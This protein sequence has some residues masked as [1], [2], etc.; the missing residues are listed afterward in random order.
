[1][2]QA[3]AHGTHAHGSPYAA[4]GHLAGPAFAGLIDALIVQSPVEFHFPGA[5]TSDEAEK[6]W[7]WMARDLGAGL[8]DLRRLDGSETA[9]MSVELVLPELMNRARQAIAEAGNDHDR[10]RR[11]RTAVGGEEILERVPKIFSALKTRGLIEKA[12]GFGRAANGLTE[13]QAL[14]LA[15]QSMPLKDPD[16]AAILFQAAV[17]QVA[18]P[19]RLVTA[20]IKVAGGASE[21]AMLRA[22]FGPLIDAILCHAQDQIHPLLQAGTF[23]DMDLICRAVDRFHRLMRAVTAYIELPRSSNWSRIAG[24]LTGRISERLDPRLRNVPSDVN[25]S[26]RA[27]AGTDRLDADQVFVALSGMYLL[28]AVRDSRDSLALNAVFDDVWTQIGQALEIHVDRLLGQVKAN[29]MDRVVAERFEAAMKMAELR[30]GSQFADNIR[31]A[32][33]LAEKRV[34]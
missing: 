32:K 22:G 29:P 33:D 10:L 31:H 14:A 9:H 3:T 12:Q 21:A 20:A 30:F 13:E 28:A 17:G 1:M 23:T 25:L 18:E 19:R 16:L 34:G 8:I 6:V 5:I 27:R 2:V 7:V 26:L 4:Q 11:L 15:L 24:V